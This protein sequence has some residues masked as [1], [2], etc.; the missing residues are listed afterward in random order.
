MGQGMVHEQKLEFQETTHFRGVA[1][2][3][4]RSLYDLKLASSNPVPFFSVFFFCF[5]VP[6]LL[7]NDWVEAS[8]DQ[9]AAFSFPKFLPAPPPRFSL[10]VLDFD[11]AIEWLLKFSFF[12]GADSF[13][14]GYILGFCSM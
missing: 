13:I 1:Q 6:L 4:V 8:L 10:Q 7:P 5:F 14:K 11:I 12:N 2:L 3:G 9:A